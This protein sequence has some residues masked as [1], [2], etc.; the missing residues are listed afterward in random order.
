MKF[1]FLLLIALN[2]FASNA[3][4]TNEYNSL[5][6]KYLRAVLNSDDKKQQE[7][8]KKIVIVGKKLK[9]DVSK[10]EKEINKKA[11]TKTIKPA[12]KTYTKVT[13]KAKPSKYSSSKY[14]I[15]SVY[16]KNNM[17]I[18]NFRHNVSKNYIDFTEQ[19]KNGLYFDI[20]DFKGKFK[21][22]SPTKLEMPGVSRIKI[23]QKN[24]KTL[25][26][27]LRDQRNIKTIYILNGR[28]IIIKV[29]DVN[30]KT[31]SLN[32]TIKV[33]KS[34]FNSVNRNKTIV[35]DAGHG[36]K[37]A[38]AVGKGRK[39]YEK[40]VVLD[41]T[42][43]LYSILKSRGYNVYMT[44][45]T[46][47]FIKV[48]NR[49]VLANRKNAD[50]FLSI[51]A[52]AAPKSV[53]HKA[54]GIETYFLSPARSERAK[55]VAAL[56][57]KTDMRR[58]NFSSKNTFLTILNQ[59]KITASQKLGIDVHQNLLYSARQMYK[60]VADG[61]VR[62]GP[63]WVLVG[64]QMPSILLEIGYITHK[65]EGKRIFRKA[66]QNQLAKGIADGID[67]YF[68]KNNF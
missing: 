51:H 67:A 26:I 50:I 9:K 39:Q 18:L 44:R 22:A 59:S 64:A 58:M 53:V 25:R 4:L 17:I 35:L 61:G 63:F 29:L 28:S 10:Y 27:Y 40:Y 11:V 47:R 56:E 49:T 24:P 65:V 55:R 8:L 5:K 20:F 38:G 16:V 48:K 7:Y 66:Y 36:G 21:D 57:N 33:N 60:D 45:K 54:R 46:D 31:A 13:S 34:N 6:T 52:N 19:K 37:D 32:K 62:E 3:L 43:K 12:K 15:K 68:E 42:K 30:A 41:V 23:Y 1:L 2:L 14:N